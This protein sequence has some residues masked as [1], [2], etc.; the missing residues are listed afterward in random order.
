MIPVRRN[1]DTNELVFWLDPDA[2]ITRSSNLNAYSTAQG[3]KNLLAGTRNFSNVC[4]PVTDFSYGPSSQTPLNFT[5]SASGTPAPDGSGNPTTLITES[6]DTIDRTHKMRFDFPITPIIEGGPYEMYT[7]SIH[8]KVSSGS[9]TLLINNAN[10]PSSGSITVDPATGTIIASDTD[11]HD[12]GVESLGGGWYRFWYTVIFDESTQTTEVRTELGIFMA[13][14]TGDTTYQGDG[15]SGLI[16]YGHQWERGVL[17]NYVETAEGVDF[18]VFKN[19]KC[20]DANYNKNPQYYPTTF[21]GTNFRF[22]GIESGLT[23]GFVTPIRRAPRPGLHPDGDEQKFSLLAHTLFAWIRLDPNVDPDQ[24]NNN[25][26]LCATAIGN[27]GGR[28]NNG[29][30]GITPDGTQIIYKT[31]LQR[32]S[33]GSGVSATNRSNSFASVTDKWALISCSFNMTYNAAPATVDFY[34]NGQLISSA[35]PN[36]S[37]QDLIGIGGSDGSLSIGYFNTQGLGAAG[38]FRGLMN[39]CGIYHK[40]LNATEHE[41]LY[42][43]TKYKFI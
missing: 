36:P 29:V 5:L 20:S 39:I 35:N 34:L 32:I 40:A 2:P 6:L 16:I 41:A 13:D 4:P 10:N 38:Q 17:S 14:A 15:T 21:D 3:G 33:G 11:N 28:N 12:E 9:R 7:H 1:I 37:A 26:G 27:V 22:N 8:V 30:F 24:G 42:N 23:S 18:D 31:R 25:W 19:R 43:A